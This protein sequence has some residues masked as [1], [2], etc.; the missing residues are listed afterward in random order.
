MNTLSVAKEI[1]ISYQCIS[2]IFISCFSLVISKYL[3]KYIILYGKNKNIFEDKW[4]EFIL[5]KK[6]EIKTST[7]QRL[8]HFYI[9]LVLLITMKIQYQ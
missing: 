7:L 1:I 5:P 9:C 2:K 4:C 8:A 3:I 6:A